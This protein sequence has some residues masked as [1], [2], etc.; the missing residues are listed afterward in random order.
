MKNWPIALRIAFVAIVAAIPAFF[1]ALLEISANPDRDPA[2]T[3]AVFL[4]MIGLPL[5][6]I[7]YVWLWPTAQMRQKQQRT[8]HSVESRWHEKASAQSFWWL[9]AILIWVD[10]AGGLLE[11]S[12]LSP[13][14]LYHVIAVA[15]VVFGLN[16]LSVRRSDA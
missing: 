5:A 3:Y 11:I 2:A 1:L 8:E 6:F 12:W 9:A 7:L 16:Y 13:M 14:R 4:P 15:A 10:V